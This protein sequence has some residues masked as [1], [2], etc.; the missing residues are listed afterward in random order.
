M[1]TC[2]HNFFLFQEQ[3]EVAG[4][5]LN[6]SKLEHCCRQ[7]EFSTKDLIKA[8]TYEDIHGNKYD[9]RTNES[10]KDSL[11]LKEELNV[12]HVNGVGRKSLY[13]DFPYFNIG[14]QLPQCSMEASMKGINTFF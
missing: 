7:C 12:T 11:A 13:T 5:L 9:E 14:K 4:L 10:L 3:N 6:F 2:V 1:L 8:N